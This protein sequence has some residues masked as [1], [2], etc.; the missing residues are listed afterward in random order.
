[1]ALKEITFRLCARILSHTFQ[2]IQLK[3]VQP[4]EQKIQKVRAYLISTHEFRLMQA[5]SS[6][7]RKEGN[8]M[9]LTIHSSYL[10]CL[11]Q[12]LVFSQRLR[13]LIQ[14]ESAQS[15]QSNMDSNSKSFVVSSAGSASTY[16]I[17]SRNLGQNGSKGLPSRKGL[18]TSTL[19]SSL[20]SASPEIL[21]KNNYT[22]SQGIGTMP[23]LFLDDVTST[24]ITIG[25]WIDP[26]WVKNL[27]DQDLNVEVQVEMAKIYFEASSAED[28]RKKKLQHSE[29]QR[30]EFKP[31]RLPIT[32]VVEYVPHVAQ[33]S[34]ES[35]AK[36]IF[37]ESRGRPRTISTMTSTDLDPDSR[38]VFRLTATTTQDE[39]S[40]ENKSRNIALKRRPQKDDSK[41]ISATTGSNSH[42]EASATMSEKPKAIQVDD[43]ERKKS[44]FSEDEDEPKANGVPT[45]SF[46]L[47]SASAAA[48]LAPV[49]RSNTLTA[50]TL[51]EMMFMLDPAACGGNLI[52]S[53]GNLVVTNTVNKK[54][55]AVRATA[56]FSSGIHSWEVH[57][58]KCV[59]K[60]I[61]VG[62]VA[63][64]ASV[65]NYVGSD[66]YGWG[67][68]ANKAIWHNKGKMRS[69]GELFRQGDTI[70][71]KLDMEVGTLSFT[72]NG[73][74]LGVAVEGLV[75]DMY[76]AFS[77]YNQDD[78]VSLVAGGRVTGRNRIDNAKDAIDSTAGDDFDNTD[79]KE[80]A[81]G[82]SAEL[83]TDNLPSNGSFSRRTLDKLDIALRTGKALSGM[84]ME[85]PVDADVLAW[86]YDFF[87]RWR[88]GYML[89]YPTID[90]DIKALD[91]SPSACMHFGFP[92]QSCIRTTKGDVQVLGEAEGQLFLRRVRIS[93]GKLKS[94]DA[95]IAMQRTS[96]RIP[97]LAHAHLLKGTV[98]YP[99]SRKVIRE[100]RVNQ[101]ISSLA[102]TESSSSGKNI[103]SHSNLF[104]RSNS[105]DVQ[106]NSN[107]DEKRDP[108]NGNQEINRK[109]KLNHPYVQYLDS[110]TGCIPPTRV[111]E[112]AALRHWWF[113]A[114]Q[115]SVFA[116]K[117]DTELLRILNELSL[118]SCV[119][120]NK[121]TGIRT[122]G[123]SAGGA[124]PG[125]WN[126]NPEELSV[127]INTDR[128][129]KEAIASSEKYIAQV[130]E[131]I[132][133]ERN[134][135]AEKMSHEGNCKDNDQNRQTASKGGDRN[136]FSEDSVL[137]I[138]YALSQHGISVLRK[139]TP[140]VLKARAGILLFFNSVTEPVLP[141]IEL[142]QDGTSFS[143]SGSAPSVGN[144]AAIGGVAPSKW[145]LGNELIESRR[146]LFTATKWRLLC[147]FMA[148]TAT[149]RSSLNSQGKNTNSESSSNSGMG[150]KV[151][152]TVKSKTSATHT[153]SSVLQGSQVQPK[154]DIT[155]LGKDQ[156]NSLTRTPMNTGQVSGGLQSLELKPSLSESKW[157]GGTKEQSPTSTLTPTTLRSH[158]ATANNNNVPNM[159]KEFRSL[160]KASVFGQVVS[161]LHVIPPSMFRFG[162]G[163][164]QSCALKV[165]FKMIDI[166]AS[167][168]DKFKANNSPLASPS[169]LSSEGVESQL[170][171]DQ[172]DRENQEQ[173]FLHVAKELVWPLR[174]F[175][176]VPQDCFNAEHASD[177]RNVLVPS[178][179]HAS[180]WQRSHLYRYVGKMIG[181]GLR[182]CTPFDLPLAPFIWKLLINPGVPLFFDDVAPLDE[183]GALQV[184][185]DLELAK[186]HSLEIEETF[187]A[188]LG[189]K[190]PEK[191]T[192]DV[193]AGVRVR[194]RVLK[195]RL[196][197][198]RVALS[199]IRAG[200]LDVIPGHTLSLFTSQELKE[201]VC[202]GVTSSR[203][204]R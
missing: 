187:R 76:P 154:L 57:I 125:V 183:A 48:S 24:S 47:I 178:E 150:D 173:L 128:R 121:E 11:S 169:S 25:W 75:G 170:H 186:A 190:M 115:V 42:D 12:L 71:V 40:N 103:S 16:N 112:A 32:P 1:M 87:L 77:L 117:V 107:L 89:R 145:S 198:V 185:T 111:H 64:N 81:V 124:L 66:R 67:Y 44:S 69:Y 123:V 160:L 184:L 158:M 175:D 110:N 168:N 105:V 204:D 99:W 179:I 143:A 7:I 159:R 98:A 17:V 129:L 56:S 41:T 30:L 144:F 58:D 63:A 163:L 14:Y 45:V 106:T 120:I 197:R 153:S 78:Q 101:S 165:S 80:S 61:F 152:S 23:T 131:K 3:S 174:M 62:V 137:S 191:F 27:A 5:F 59:S 114:C 147:M 203:Q 151:S 35:K 132:Q 193:E 155:L 146:H 19:S 9:D 148:R 177:N 74:D 181:I 149:N 180:S 86:C 126:V 39:R 104:D 201:L 29:S 122:A 134:N 38:Y 156:Y 171:P 141:L 2:N 116:P 113:G 161:S 8:S 54:W 100:L 140:G 82:N 95:S 36:N 51:S 94:T 88:E 26:D 162:D 13:T 96:S 18:T 4:S 118:E 37:S 97:P 65:E 92:S 164:A 73:K 157:S 167:Y 139:I 192:I 166:E 138:G 70:G 28:C 136:A 43:G 102:S 10:Q 20:L 55:N 53:S 91:A 34:H 196:D 93:A 200:M 188:Y 189:S 202:E 83:K 50:E 49:Y 22:G 127:K 109:D 130:L 135:D 194:F 142:W 72:R 60:N 133:R 84:F 79:L 119:K 68:L 33:N 199:E 85:T 31:L 46:G 176:V 195:D 21:R 108:V 90:G 182:T 172:M 6:R 15:N 52:M